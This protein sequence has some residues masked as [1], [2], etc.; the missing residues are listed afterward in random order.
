MCE[1][2]SVLMARGGAGRIRAPP[3]LAQVAH[4]A[5]ECSLN[6]L[7]DLGGSSLHQFDLVQSRVDSERNHLGFRKPLPAALVVEEVDE[8][9]F[10][11]GPVLHLFS[12][13]ENVQRGQ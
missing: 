1:R 4:G 13:F 11:S 12:D 9:E 8:V 6:G 10:L 3:G 7:A 2:V 5:V